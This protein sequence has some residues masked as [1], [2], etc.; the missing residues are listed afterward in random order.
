MMLPSVSVPGVADGLG[1]IRLSPSWS[2]NNDVAKTFAFHETRR[3]RQGGAD[4]PVQ[5]G[6]PP[7]TKTTGSGFP[8][9]GTATTEAE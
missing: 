5:L 4:A 2:I 6:D 3:L 1:K 8:L 7:G 9:E